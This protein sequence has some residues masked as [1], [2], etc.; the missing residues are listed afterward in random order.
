MPAPAL[1]EPLPTPLPGTVPLRRE[2]RDPLGRAMRG[3]VTLTGSERRDGDGITVLPVAVT[4]D[5]HG[6][7]L[8][9]AL[10]PDTYTLS[11][12]LRTVDGDRVTDTTTVTLT[13]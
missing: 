3:E 10:P 1:P 11:A 13:A 6:G 7:V 5:L 8:E 9:V 2:Y 12:A 4:V